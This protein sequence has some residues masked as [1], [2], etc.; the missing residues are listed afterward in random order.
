MFKVGDKVIIK[1][2]AVVPENVVPLNYLTKEARTGVVLSVTMLGIYKVG[3]RGIAG[4]FTADE[5]KPV[6]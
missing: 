5:L 4:L 1:K 2:K 6:S 3:Y